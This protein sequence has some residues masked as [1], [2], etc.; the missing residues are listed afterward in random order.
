VSGFCVAG[1][2]HDRQKIVALTLDFY[3]GDNEAL[4]QRN[5]ALALYDETRAASWRN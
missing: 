4:E 3:G 2:A 1:I 5:K